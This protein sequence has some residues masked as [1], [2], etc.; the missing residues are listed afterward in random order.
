MIRRHEPL[1]VQQWT[2]YDPRMDTCGV[3]VLFAGGGSLD[4]TATVELMAWLRPEYHVQPSRL[5][6]AYWLPKRQRPKFVV[7]ERPPLGLQ[8]EEGK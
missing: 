8:V 2:G 6:A 7:R 4:T 1:G 3:R 5:S